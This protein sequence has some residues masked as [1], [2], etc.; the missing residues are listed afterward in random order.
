MGLAEAAQA[1]DASCED[2]REELASARDRGVRSP[3][4]ARRHLRD[5]G[6]CRGFDRALRSTGKDLAALLPGPGLFGLLAGILGGGA[7]AGGGITGVAGGGAAAATATKVAVALCCAAVTAGGAASIE[8]TLHAAT[9]QTRAA[10]VPQT[11][12]SE[13]ADAVSPDA[14]PALWM[15]AVEADAGVVSPEPAPTAAPSDAVAVAEPAD[16]EPGADQL[17]VAA[18]ARETTGGATVPDELA[19]DPAPAT[20]PASPAVLTAPENADPA[21]APDE[22]PLATSASASAAGP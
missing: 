15:A 13:S 8:R 5:C 12:G 4:R 1:R 9:P 7:T 3:A 19:E 21:T 10:A 6:E 18:D 14:A 22:A 20:D 2:I 17:D 11:G 16:R